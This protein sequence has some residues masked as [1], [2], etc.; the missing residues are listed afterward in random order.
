MQR[1]AHKHAVSEGCDLESLC[2]LAKTFISLETLKLRLRM[3]PAPKPIDTT[4]LPTKQRRVEQQG[5]S[6][7]ETPDA[8]G[9]YTKSDTNKLDKFQIYP[10]TTPEPGIPDSAQD[11]EFKRMN[12]PKPAKESL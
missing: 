2:N 5:F 12:L 9:V 3:K 8:T 7:I 4:K 1:I 10:P 6:E 11:R